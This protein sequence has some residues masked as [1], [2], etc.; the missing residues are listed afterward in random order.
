ML[1][2]A[3][4]AIRAGLWVFPVQPGDK[5]PIWTP[6]G[7]LKWGA[8]ATCDEATIRDWWG[9]KCPTANI[10]VAAKHGRLLIVDCDMPKSD[11]RPAGFKHCENG[12]D[13]FAEICERVGHPLPFDTLTVRTPSGGCH[14]YY[15]NPDDVPL[16]NSSLLRG[17][18]DIRA[19]GGSDGGY[20]VGPGS[21]GANGQ[22]YVVEYSAPIMMAP[23]WLLELCQEQPPKPPRPAL[24]A[25]RGS[26]SFSNQAKTDGLVNQVR[27]A[28]EGN[29]NAALFWS[30]AKYAE[31]GLHIS[32]AEA[33]L[34]PA[35][36]AAGLSRG[37]ILPTISS[38]Y[39]KAAR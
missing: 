21:T 38:A 25:T 30:A 7:R 1:E 18:V 10:G 29:R 24:P 9:S 15:R 14:Y 13:A 2:I 36:L 34:T 8:A 20:V 32:E 23:P 28:Q 31:E 35:A 26:G 22:K 39:R 4:K 27:F 12:Q 16:R 6:N 19:N 5:T 37:E 3:L 33:D 17:F 11:V